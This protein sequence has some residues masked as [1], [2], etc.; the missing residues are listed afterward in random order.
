[1]SHSHH[2]TACKDRQELLVSKEKVADLVAE[3]HG[4]EQ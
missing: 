3:E 2:M 1:M 4:Y